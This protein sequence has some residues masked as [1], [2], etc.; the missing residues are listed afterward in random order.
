MAKTP[1]LKTKGGMAIVIIVGLFIVFFIGSEYRAYQVRKAIKDVFNNES[2]EPAKNKKIIE[3]KV[4]EEFELATIKVKVNG[5]E[6]KQVIS[7]QYGSPAIAKENAK[8]VVLNLDITNI[9]KDTFMLLDDIPLIDSQERIYG[10]Y[11]AIG[12]IDNYLDV[13]ELSPSITENG[14]MV[15]E[16]PNDATSYALAIDKGGTNERYMVKLK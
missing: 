4:G 1:F 3:K 7:S 11:T 8:F 2:G 6:E 9:T 14:V 5:V 15:Y 10:N 16:L 13:R 12:A